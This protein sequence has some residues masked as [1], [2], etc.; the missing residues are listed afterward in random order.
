MAVCVMLWAYY[1][2][3]M[4]YFSRYC[5]YPKHKQENPCVYDIVVDLSIM[6]AGWRRLFIW[7]KLWSLWTTCFFT[8][9]FLMVHGKE[10]REKTQNL[11]YMI[12]SGIAGGVAGCV[13][14]M[15]AKKTAL[16]NSISLFLCS[17]IT[18]PRLPLLHS[19]GSRFFSKPRILYSKSM[20][21]CWTLVYFV[22]ATTQ[23][24][25]ASIGTFTGAFKA[26]RD[27]VR[28][29]GVLGLFQGHSVTLLRIFPYATIRF[30]AYEQF[31]AVS[32]GY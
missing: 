26:G 6:H 13:V 30:I 27:I 7:L 20:L 8:L 14:R 16:E 32:R 12:R 15:R 5:V 23:L 25:F 19:I 4:S 24:S 18:R 9:A 11:D 17:Y 31:R 3:W 28:H 29:T 2:R 22:H 21:V 10:Q 1:A